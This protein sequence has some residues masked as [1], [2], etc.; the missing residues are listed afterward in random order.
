MFCLALS[1]KLK[2]IILVNESYFKVICI[3]VWLLFQDIDYDGFRKF[4]DTYLE[5]STP[6]DLSRHLFL[7][8]I[9]KIPRGVDSKAFKVR[10]IIL[11]RFSFIFLEIFAF[12]THS[13]F[14][15]LFRFNLFGLIVYFLS[16]EIVSRLCLL[17]L[18]A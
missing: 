10:H 4:L 14:C 2:I 6:D 17:F 13:T 8:F 16:Y 7:S 11:Y 18:L 12:F 9:K 15:A 3:C 5:V 1:I